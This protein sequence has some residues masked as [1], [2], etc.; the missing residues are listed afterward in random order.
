MNIGNAE[1]ARAMIVRMIDEPYDNVKMQRVGIFSIIYDYAY[2]IFAQRMG[3]NDSSFVDD[4][5]QHLEKSKIIDDKSELLLK[6]AAA[7]MYG[8]VSV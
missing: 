5:L 7:Q 1:K 4:I 2:Q 3:I 6:N 8:G